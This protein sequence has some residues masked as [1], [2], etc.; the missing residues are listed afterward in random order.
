MSQI[1][2]IPDVA[3]GP[4]LDSV[5]RAL[6][7]TCFTQPHDVVFQH[8]RYAQE[9]PA[10]RWLIRDQAGKVVSH[11]AAHEKS[12]EAEGKSYRIGGI[13]EVCVDP[14]H[15]G[16]GQAKQLLAAAHLW[17]AE[18][19]FDYAVLFGEREVYASSGYTHAMVLFDSGAGLE[20]VEVQ[21]LPLGLRPWPA[22]EVRLIGPP[23]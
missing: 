5:L 1:E 9:M 14:K 7:S 22:S 8:R 16:K 10:H 3:V 4:E 11:A 19:G 12:I 20:K 17:L 21:V 6:L 2:Y 13:A 15:R 18:N 23:F